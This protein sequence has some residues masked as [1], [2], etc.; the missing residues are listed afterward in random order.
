MYKKMLIKLFTKSDDAEGRDDMKR[1]R[2]KETKMKKQEKLDPLMMI[3]QS[4][5][6]THVDN[7]LWFK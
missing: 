6:K 1:E 2:E 7:L 4:K 5:L 3:M